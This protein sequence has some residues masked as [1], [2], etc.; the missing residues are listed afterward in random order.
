MT[1][2]CHTAICITLKLAHKTWALPK[3]KP[4]ILDL[5][6]VFIG[7]SLSLR[8]RYFG[9]APEG[10]PKWRRGP[11]AELSDFMLFLFFRL[12]PLALWIG[13]HG[14]WWTVDSCCTFKFGSYTVPFI[15]RS[16]SILWPSSR[17]WKRVWNNPLLNILALS[18]KPVLQRSCVVLIISP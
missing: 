13:H 5:G 2:A 10:G 16:D 11:K 18:W 15:I 17:I 12:L 4:K 9:L 3:N 6:L 1:L 8:T 14:C 7:S